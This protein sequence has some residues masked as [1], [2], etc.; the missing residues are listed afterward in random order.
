MRAIEFAVRMAV[1]PAVAAEGAGDAGE[2]EEVVRFALV[3]S[4]ER[5]QPASQAMVR[6]MVQR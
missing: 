2:G 5:R 1:E 3:A 4:V 6:S